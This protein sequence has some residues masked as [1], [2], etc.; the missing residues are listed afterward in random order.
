MMNQ[1]TNLTN[2]GSA[3]GSDDS[4]SEGEEKFAEEN[5]IT[6]SPRDMEKVAES[7]LNPPAPNEALKA[8]VSRRD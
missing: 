6:L 4:G 7:I 1:R 8:A 2:H 5:P 3:I